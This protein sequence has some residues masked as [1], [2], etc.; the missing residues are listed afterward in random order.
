MFSVVKT[1]EYIGSIQAFKPPKVAN[2]DNDIWVRL[3]VYCLY[4]I[5]IVSSMNITHHTGKRNGGLTAINLLGVQ[6]QSRSE[7]LHHRP[8]GCQDLS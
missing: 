7:E 4:R 2:R 5:W 1:L 8:P 3:G 6:V